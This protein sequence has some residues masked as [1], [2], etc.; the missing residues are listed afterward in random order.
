MALQVSSPVAQNLGNV[1]YSANSRFLVSCVG[2]RCSALDA[3]SLETLQ[4]FSC[5]DKIEKVEISPDSCYI[6]CALSSRG[7]VQVFSMADAAW[8]CRINESVAGIASAKWSPDSRHIAVESDFGIQMAI[9]S[10]VDNTSNIIT[11]PKPGVGAVFS[12]CGR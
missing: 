10:L 2:S 3:A 9:W 7:I 11:S 8:R 12:D 1:A 4:V 5:V 6:L